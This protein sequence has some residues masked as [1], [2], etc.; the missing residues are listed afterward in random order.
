MRRVTYEESEKERRN[1]GQHTQLTIL[2]PG[3]RWHGMPHLEDAIVRRTLREIGTHPIIRPLIEDVMSPKG[4]RSAWRSYEL[5]NP[6]LFLTQ[7]IPSIQPE[8]QLAS[9]VVAS[10][11]SFSIIRTGYGATKQDWHVDAGLL[12]TPWGYEQNYVFDTYSL[13]IAL[14][15][16]SLGMGQTGVCPGVHSP[17]GGDM[18]EMDDDGHCECFFASDNGEDVGSPDGQKYEVS[19]SCTFRRIDEQRG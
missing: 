11:V 3:N 5:G 4:E 1:P 15:D 13:A 18:A 9:L 16:I 14:Q 2:D 7:S 6:T 10:V 19:R 8:L 17:D 12:K